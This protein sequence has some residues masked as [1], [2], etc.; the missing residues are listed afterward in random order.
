MAQLWDMKNDSLLFKME[1]GT[2]IRSGEFSKNKEQIICTWDDGIIT[3]YDATTGNLTLTL[4]STLK[5]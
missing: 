5:L 2:Y 3:V 4:S 1:R